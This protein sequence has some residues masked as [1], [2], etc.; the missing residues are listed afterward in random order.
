MY[1][2]WKELQ[3]WEWKCVAG[4]FLG[5]GVGGDSDIND[6]LSNCREGHNKFLSPCRKMFLSTGCFLKSR[7]ISSAGTVEFI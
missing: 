2:L 3:F 4:F 1:S 7:L 6:G 5:E